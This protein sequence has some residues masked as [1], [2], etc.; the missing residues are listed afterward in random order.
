[1]FV[2]T[3]SVAVMKHTKTRFGQ[4]P[5]WIGGEGEGNMAGA[6][7]AATLVAKKLGILL[8]G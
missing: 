7:K 8:R 6:V 2:C 4:V 1:M 5:V 3:N